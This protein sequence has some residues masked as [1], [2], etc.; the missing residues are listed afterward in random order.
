MQQQLL[1]PLLLLGLTAK[2]PHAPVLAAAAAAATAA[3]CRNL[4][5]LSHPP[6]PLQEE[7]HHFLPCHPSHSRGAAHYQTAHCRRYHC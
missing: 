6:S 2:L 5:H 7:L 3:T 1:L 4:H